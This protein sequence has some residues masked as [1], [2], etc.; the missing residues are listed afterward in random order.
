[1]ADGELI[2]QAF[3]GDIKRN[4]PARICVSNTLGK[5]GIQRYKLS[6]AVVHMLTDGRSRAMRFS[7]EVG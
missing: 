7:F 4:R 6:T 5:C 2:A 1:M 3:E